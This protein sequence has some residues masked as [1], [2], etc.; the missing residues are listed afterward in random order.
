[1]TFQEPL[2]LIEA[3]VPAFVGGAIGVFAILGIRELFKETKVAFK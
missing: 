2:S 1:M 3:I